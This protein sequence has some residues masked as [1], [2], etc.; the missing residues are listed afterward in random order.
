MA[1]HHRGGQNTP[2]GV[3]LKQAGAVAHLQ[4]GGRQGAQLQIA[5]QKGHAFQHVLQL[6]A[7][8]PRVHIDSTAHR[9]GDAAGKF[10]PGQ[11]QC[12]GLAAKASQRLPRPG[13]NTHKVGIRVGCFHLIQASHIHNGTVKAGIV[14]QRVGAISQQIDTH[15]LCTAVLQNTAQLCCI[16]RGAPERRRTPDFKRRVPCQYLLLHKGQLLCCQSLGQRRSCLFLHRFP[17]LNQIELPRAAAPITPASLCS[18]QAQITGNL[19]VVMLRVS[20]SA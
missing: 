14:K 10:Q 13:G 3:F 9:A 17:P 8:G 6:P 18:W 5:V 2:V 15:A 11:S 16:A 12:L 7:V 20:F 4:I 19:P 1:Q